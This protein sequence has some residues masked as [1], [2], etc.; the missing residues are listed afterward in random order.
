MTSLQ[1]K[2]IHAFTFGEA[3]YFVTMWKE[4]LPLLSA[5]LFNLH[6]EEFQ[7][8]VAEMKGRTREYYSRDPVQ[9]GMREPM[10]VGNSGLYVETHWNN[11][12]TYLIC[13]DLLKRFGYGED[14][15]H[16]D[17]R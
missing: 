14:D 7:A 4:L 13:V 17:Y 10:P 5:I 8:R 12:K 15:F 2:F 9:A 16:I 1:G 11:D 3:Q 6:P